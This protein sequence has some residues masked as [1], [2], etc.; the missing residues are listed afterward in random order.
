MRSGVKGIGRVTKY[1][2]SNS[3]LSVWIGAAAFDSLAGENE[4]TFVAKHAP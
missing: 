4:M 1:C 2:L 3:L